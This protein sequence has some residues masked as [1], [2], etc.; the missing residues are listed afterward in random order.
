[1]HVQSDKAVQARLSQQTY[2]VGA[3]GLDVIREGKFSTRAAAHARLSQRIYEAGVEG[4]DVMRAGKLRTMRRSSMTFRSTLRGQRRWTRRGQA[5]SV[6][7]GGPCATFSTDQHGSAEGLD[8][9]GY[10]RSV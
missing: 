4:R 7:G 1:M 3:S 10:A 6:G 8:V 2:M 9:T 5:N